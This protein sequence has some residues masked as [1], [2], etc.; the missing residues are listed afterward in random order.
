MT[1]KNSAVKQ[2]FDQLV[3]PKS[4]SHKGENGKMVFIGGSELFHA[5]VKWSLDTASRFV[6][7]LFYSSV[8]QNEQLITEAKQHFWNGI[9]IPQGQVEDYITEADVVLIG[10]GMERT[11]ETAQQ[12][13]AL[14]MQF[15]QKKWVVDAGAL[16]MADPELFTDTMIITPHSKELERVATHEQKTTQE[17]IQYLTSKGVSILL[18]GETDT[19]YV[20]DE[21]ITISG[22][23]PGMTK[24][25]TGDVLAGVLAGLY[26]TNTAKTAL[27]V[28]SVVNKRA[29]ETLASQQG[30]FFNAS[31][32]AARI[33]KTFHSLLK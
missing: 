28:S 17:T 30:P 13:N 7:M 25:G 14:L 22:G 33:P 21:M 6:D 4:S 2:A 27:V 12:V 11:E 19:I 9:V 18:K 3:V 15:P 31:D 23:H 32:L 1:T 8:P 10:P 5:P 24:G 16:Q 26:A 29:G 20:Q